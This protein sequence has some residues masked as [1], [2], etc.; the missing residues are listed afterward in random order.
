VAA[1]RWS[2][3]GIPERPR[4]W[5]IQAASR[6][7]IDQ[8]RSDRSRRGRESLSAL[9]EPLAPGVDNSGRDDTLNVLFMCCHSALSAA[10][11]IALT[12]RAVGGLTTAQVARAFLVPE[13]TM[14]QRISRAKQQ[15]KASAVPFA[16][17]S[18]EE[19]A[20]A[21]LRLVLHILYLI[22]NEGY[23]ASEGG[24]LQRAELSNEAIRLARIVHRMIPDD[25]EVAGLLALMLL[26]DARRSARIDAAG[27]L[28]P[29]AVQDRTLWDGAL[30]AEGVAL[31]NRAMES[32]TVGEYQL[33][34]AI[35]AIHD[36]AVDAGDTDWQQI[37]A[38][39][40]L[41]ERIT[42]N[43]IVT[44]NRAVAAAM[45]DGPRAGLALL[46]GIDARLTGHHHVHAVR[47]H[48][49]EMVGDFEG[50]VKHYRAAASRTTSLPEQRYL[51]MQASRLASRPV[52]PGG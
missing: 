46:D 25:G 26:T 12:L 27:E 6:R 32:G 43:P 9:R 15:I 31:L 47:A 4:G 36:Q 7:L 40:G 17:P 14:A 19:D 10:S 22:F 34:A 20:E 5:L 44:L 11:A 16:M 38:L 21:R 48:L 29:L 13:T 1:T 35:A 24:E 3:D 42:G 51:A 45:A 50:A 23:A 37:L 2:Q 49:L 33:Q 39:Y 8:W 41:L 18:A 30:I 28:V 52:A